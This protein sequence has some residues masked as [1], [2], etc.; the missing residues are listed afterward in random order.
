[1]TKHAPGHKEGLL[2]KHLD[3]FIYWDIMSTTKSGFEPYLCIT[4]GQV[5]YASV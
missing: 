2:R 5:V 1:M 3:R 4:R